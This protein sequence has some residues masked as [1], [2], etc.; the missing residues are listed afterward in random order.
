M[1][2]SRVRGRGCSWGPPTAPPCLGVVPSASLKC[3]GPSVVLGP[4]ISGLSLFLCSETRLVDLGVP[5]DLWSR[6][7]PAL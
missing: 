1:G 6:D 3:L 4:F 5:P 7:G 2:T